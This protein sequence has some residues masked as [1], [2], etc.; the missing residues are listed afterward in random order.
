LDYSRGKGTPVKNR[1]IAALFDRIADALEIRGESGFKVVAYRKAARVLQDMTEDIEA[2]A[3][4]GRLE[5]IPGIGSR[6]AGKIEEYIRTGGMAKL[7]EVMEDVPE[8]LLGLLEIQGLGGKTIHLIHEKL[9][10]RGL[11]DL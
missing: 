5:S 9:G 7:R 3:R 1:E 2:V 10:L 8:G 4:A 6:L 11:E